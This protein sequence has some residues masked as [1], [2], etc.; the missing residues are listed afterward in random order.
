[1]NSIAQIFKKGGK[2]LSKPLSK[3]NK[4]VI[5]VTDKRIDEWNKSVNGNATTRK[6]KGIIFSKYHIYSNLLF[7]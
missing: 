7:F 5:G 2:D 3:K 1:M 4:S 6:I